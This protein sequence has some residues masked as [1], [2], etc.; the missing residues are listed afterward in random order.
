MKEKSNYQEYL[1]KNSQEGNKNSFLDL[2]SLHYKKVHQVVF[3][4][5]SS[6]SHSK[7]LTI[8]VFLKV[9]D[10][11]KAF[12]INGNFEEWI[13]E[14]AAIICF[15][16]Y[17]EENELVKKN[18][19]DNNEH[20]EN[21]PLGGFN[22]L[23]TF[24]LKL[25]EQERIALTLYTKLNFSIAKIT[26]IFKDVPELKMIQILTEAINSSNEIVKSKS[27]F[28]SEHINLL[29][30]AEQR[31]DLKL[32]GLDQS[33]IDSFR[34]L[35]KE[36][37]SVFSNFFVDPSIL[38]DLRETLIE[39]E[40]E[41]NKQKEK[42]KNKRE[43]EKN[44]IKQEMN[45]QKEFAL[46][47]TTILDEEKV[48]SLVKSVE[49]SDK[50]N[51]LNSASMFILSAAILV[52]IV[53]TSLHFTKFNTP[54]SVNK[55]EGI[56]SI[57]GEGEGMNLNEG[58]RIKTYDNSEVL[59]TIPEKGTLKLGSN[60]IITLVKGYETENIILL[61]EGNV[62]YTSRNKISDISS[63]PDLL[64]INITTE[65]FQVST[66]VG[67]IFIDLN[68]E[69]LVGVKNGF[70]EIKTKNQ[71]TIKVASDYFYS[72]E[73]I[74]SIPYH[75]NASSIIKEACL[76]PD[77][78]A[79]NLDEILKNATESDMLSLWYILLA[80]DKQERL[81]IL[82]KLDE[83]IPDIKELISE[84]VIDISSGNKEYIMDTIIWFL[85]E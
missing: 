49:A 54:W 22:E 43:Q 28:S 1:I 15:Y 57:N 59:I 32:S 36:L 16:H 85:D 40:H 17:K 68:N 8:E 2:C 25:N 69:K 20:S 11:I 42:P 31:G 23:E 9:W 21:I 80:S 24:F 18:L 44:I 26:R 5:H 7:Q 63:L 83:Y 74:Y 3:Q 45:A 38:Q 48:A 73:I 58:D 29:I 12:D 60:S 53:F 34:M 33:I 10:H 4:M 19:L 76:S 62:T 52:I 47:Q 64:D 14:I 35:K 61:R 66:S 75:K 39:V 41:K 84:N 82:E 55:I 71:N 67:Q 13:K 79:Q 65:L 50:K 30:N 70:A 51:K 72:H 6:R 46:S 56:F 81:K 27:N 77:T 37:S 78:A